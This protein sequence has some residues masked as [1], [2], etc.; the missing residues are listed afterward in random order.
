MQTNKS[1]NAA[2]DKR[3]KKKMAATGSPMSAQMTERTRIK[4]ECKV[5]RAK[6]LKKFEKLVIHVPW[7]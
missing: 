5:L 2:R 3:R 4:A 7:L 1:K 6:N